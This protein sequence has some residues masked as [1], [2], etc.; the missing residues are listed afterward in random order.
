MADVR[1]WLAASLGAGLVLGGVDACIISDPTHCANTGNACAEGLVC[2]PCTPTSMAAHGCVSQA[3]VVDVLELP[4]CQ[5]GE[6][7]SGTD[8]GTSME[9]ATDFTT[10]Q[11]PPTTTV[12]PDTTM[13]D[14][15]SN[16]MTSA[17]DG[18]GCTDPD[19]T[20]DGECGGATPI[21]YN[22][23]CQRCTDEGDVTPCSSAM[24]VI[25]QEDPGGVCDARTGRCVEC[26]DTNASACMSD[27]YVCGPEN[28][29]VPC[30]EHNQ[31]PGGA[32]CHLFDAG[33]GT[34]LPADN[35]FYA[36]SNGMNC[37]DSIG[38]LANP[39]CSLDAALAL[40]MGSSEATI[41]VLDGTY[42]ETLTVSAG[43]ILAII[44]EDEPTIRAASSGPPTFA[45][46]STT[47]FSG[48]DIS[49]ATSANTS[50]GLDIQSGDVGVDD[51]RIASNSGFG[52]DVAPE[53]IRLLVRRSEI[54]TNNRGGIESAGES[55]MLE[56]VIL[57]NNGNSGSPAGGI[58]VVDG[59]T[60]E[61][62]Y[63]T[64]AENQS[65]AGVAEAISCGSSGGSVR[66]SIV[67][68]TQPDFTTGC[69]GTLDMT[70]SATDSPDHLME[71]GVMPVTTGDLNFSNLGS[72]DFRVLDGTL[73]AGVA[74]WVEGDPLSDFNGNLRPAGDGST[75]YAGA[76]V[77][78]GG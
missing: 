48:L 64:F 2:D 41:R 31:C 32:G 13:T 4:G 34:C 12:D 71:V 63:S 27:D 65:T 22:G 28:T 26:N 25:G 21:C 40:T 11:P 8:S 20:Y 33:G 43:I 69:A 55:V 78:D 50:D 73:A 39:T 68:S 59:T 57:G 54:L 56:N 10:T 35:V 15:G 52:I 30:T 6:M 23:M 36:S 60:L 53:V 9:T 24:P 18:G 44:G 77:P 16:T 19:G 66:N 62:V 14:T 7:I 38:D 76:D 17:T 42:N 72:N 51:C 45:V 61:I 74:L 5:P 46:Y 47:Y 1:H 67:V 70:Y 3:D 49:G 37:D 75:D 58:L 29:C